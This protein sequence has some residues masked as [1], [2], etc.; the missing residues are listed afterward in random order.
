MCDLRKRV[1]EGV[2]L[3][4][5]HVTLRVDLLGVV[6][7]GDCRHVIPGARTYVMGSS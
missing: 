4:T 7:L 5:G 2:N 1:W 3:E 6:T